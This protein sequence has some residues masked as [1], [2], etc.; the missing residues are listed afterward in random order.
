MRNV[1]REEAA[2]SW[3]HFPALSID[4]G[5]GSAFKQITN[6]LDA[7][8]RM[9]KRTPV[10]FDHPDQE[11]DVP[12]SYRLLRNQAVVAG[13]VMIGGVVGLYVFHAD[14]VISF[15]ADSCKLTRST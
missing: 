3:H 6:L 1:G 15:H 2:V 7:G 14:K 12:R 10:L 13:A 5:N 4:F 8:M 11:L 9:R